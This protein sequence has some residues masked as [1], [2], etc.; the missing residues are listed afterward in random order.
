MKV[1]NPG[2]CDK[3]KVKVANTGSCDE[4]KVKVTNPGSEIESILCIKQS[5]LK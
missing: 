2:S 4:T 5:I 3:T 1:A